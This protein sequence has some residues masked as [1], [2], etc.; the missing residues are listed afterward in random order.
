MTNAG[1]TVKINVAERIKVRM[2]DN[3]QT[4]LNVA[5]ATQLQDDLHINFGDGART[6]VVTSSFANGPAI[7]GNFKTFAGSGSQ[8]LQFGSTNSNSEKFVVNGMAGF[9][10]GADDDRL[11]LGNAGSNANIRADFGQDEGTFFNAFARTFSSDLSLLNL[12]GGFDAFYSQASNQLNLF[13]NAGTNPSR[14][15]VDDSSSLGRKEI[16]LV[17]DGKVNQFGSPNELNLRMRNNSRADVAVKFDKNQNALD[18][19]SIDLANGSRDLNF[20]GQSPLVA[21]NLVIQGGAGD[22]AVQ[23]AGNRRLMTG[24]LDVNLGASNNSLGFRNGLMIQGDATL[25]SVGSFNNNVPVAIEGSLTIDNSETTGPN[26]FDVDSGF[27]V[28]GDFTYM[29]SESIDDVF[30]NSNIFIAGNATI[31]LGGGNPAGAPGL[32]IQDFD[33]DNGVIRGNLNVMEGVS[34]NGAKVKVG[35]NAVVRGNININENTFE[36][37]SILGRVLGGQR[38]GT[39]DVQVTLRWDTLDDLDLAVLDPEGDQVSFR[40]RLVASGGMLDVDAN[41]GSGDTSMPVENIFWPRNGAPVGSYVASVNLFS[42]RQDIGEPINFTLT[43]TLNGQ[44][45][46]F[47]G[48]VSLSERTIEF[49]FSFQRGQG[50]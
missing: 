45:R 8:Q 22:Q 38:L 33:F 9:I 18:Q 3:S 50:A 42:Q 32:N 6:S 24:T 1:R 27:R 48:S 49:P 47:R 29:G 25:T 15:Q 43:I 21:Q 13:Q 4:Q 41:A 35:S 7:L 36:I 12:T 5:L 34:Q 28:L 23:L 39:G 10:F 46:T 26:R 31:D 2:L 40:N 14:V 17:V 30:L 37:V 20:I 16:R 11:I 19:F 44:S